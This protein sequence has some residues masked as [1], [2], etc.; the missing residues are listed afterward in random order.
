M[1][2]ATLN[3][4]SKDKSCWKIAL[5]KECPVIGLSNQ[6]KISHSLFTLLLSIMIKGS[7]ECVESL[8][9]LNNLTKLITLIINEQQV[10]ISLYSPILINYLLC[11]TFVFRGFF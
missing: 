4:F 3:D 5:S 1:K 9:C 10:C 7:L 6:D 2:T 8:G 11:K